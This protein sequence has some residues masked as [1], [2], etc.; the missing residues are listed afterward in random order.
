M[1]QY[2]IAVGYVDF[3]SPCDQIGKRWL[4][5]GAA[6]SAMSDRPHGALNQEMRCT[7]LV[8]ANIA[9]PT[10][11]CSAPDGDHLAAELVGRPGLPLADALD[12]RGVQRIDLAAALPVIRKRNVS[13][14]IAGG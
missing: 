5:L 12:L 3:L 11:L 14:I 2:V 6:K 10:A 8:G 13:A 9:V 7:G 4:A 1:P